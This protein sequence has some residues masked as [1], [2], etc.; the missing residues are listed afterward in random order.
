MRAKPGKLGI[1]SWSWNKISEIRFKKSTMVDPKKFRWEVKWVKTWLPGMT[2]ERDFRRVAAMAA[3][4]LLPFLLLAAIIDAQPL[5]P[6][7]IDAQTRNKLNDAQTLFSSL[8]AT[9]THDGQYHEVNSG[10]HH[11]VK[12]LAKMI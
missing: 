8:P 12:L 7:P 6:F 5:C 3:A 2:Q 9:K 4:T 1:N 11:K 10:Q